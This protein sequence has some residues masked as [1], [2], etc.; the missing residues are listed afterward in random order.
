MVFVLYEET[1]VLQNYIKIMHVNGT[2][3][4][5]MSI[6]CLNCEY[7]ARTAGHPTPPPAGAASEKNGIRRRMER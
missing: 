2:E 1:V 4:H 6:P 5:Y 7:R 3:N